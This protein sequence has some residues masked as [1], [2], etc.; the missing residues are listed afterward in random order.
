MKIFLNLPKRTQMKNL[1]FL[2]FPICLFSQDNCFDD[3]QKHYRSGNFLF[4]KDTE[5]LILF[6]NP[7]HIKFQENKSNISYQK[8]EILEYTGYDTIPN[9]WEKRKAEYE[10][11][12]AEFNTYFSDQ[13]KYIQLQKEKNISYAIAENRFGY[14]LLEIKNKTPKAYYIGFNKNTYINKNQK[15][16][17]I[18]DNKLSIDGSFIAIAESWGRPGHPEIEAVK[19][20]LTFQIDLNDIKK[21]SDD[22]GY[23]DFFENLIFLNP[24]SKDTDGDK[25]SDFEDLNPRYKSENTKFTK[26][27]EEII[28]KDGYQNIQEN[29]YTFETYESDCEYFQKVNPGKR[30]VLI[31]PEE[32]ARK[33]NSDYKPGLFSTYYGRIKKDPDGKTFYIPYHESSS[34]G[35]I[36]AV[37]ENGTWSLSTERGYV[38]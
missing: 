18:K 33:L 37:Y 32:K 22:D 17:F 35:K 36:I 20:F 16:I 26:L 4:I 23:N 34:G 25:I 2:L 30:R 21:D 5:E 3:G 1:L 28:E 14:W 31:F 38:I 27:F 13:F 24:N 9:F 11:K 15:E 10:K 8:D 19:D 7:K 6:N 12:Y 29:H